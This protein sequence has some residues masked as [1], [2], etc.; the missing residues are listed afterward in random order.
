MDVGISK[1][2]PPFNFFW[3]CE[4]FFSEK[5]FPKGSPFKFFAVLRQKGCWKIP[6][7]PPFSFFWHS[8]IFFRKIFS[9]KGPPSFFC[10][11]ASEWIL[12]NPKGFPLYVFSTL[13]D[14]VPKIKIS[15]FNF[16]DILQQI[17]SLKIPKNPPFS[18]LAL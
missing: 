9:P 7:G 14:F 5:F 16:F 12:E 11:F 17:G 1:R 2:V 18:F 15:P 13:W 8:N 6:K 3:H 10:S 4:I